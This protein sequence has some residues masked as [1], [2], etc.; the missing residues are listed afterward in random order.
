MEQSPLRQTIMSLEKEREHTLFFV[1]KE[2]CDSRLSANR[3]RGYF[4]LKI[5]CTV[6]M[7]C[8]I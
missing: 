2:I 4:T 8:P 6:C 5:H 7:R 1:T 3:N